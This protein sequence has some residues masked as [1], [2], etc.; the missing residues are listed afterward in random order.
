[1]TTGLIKNEMLKFIHNKKL[2]VFLL[3]LFI[4]HMLPVLMTV[5]V[6]MKT[7][8]GQVYPLTAAIFN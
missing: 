1:M 3:V 4:I 2:Y 5:L 8:N 6:N 7:L